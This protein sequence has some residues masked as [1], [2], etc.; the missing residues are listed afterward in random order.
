MVNKPVQTLGRAKASSYIDPSTVDTRH[1]D[2][3][4]PLWAP[5]TSQVEEVFAAALSLQREYDF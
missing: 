5:D 4:M 3:D 1:A 2:S